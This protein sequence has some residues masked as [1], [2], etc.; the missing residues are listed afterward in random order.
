MRALRS[1]A[2]ACGCTE[3]RTPR[4]ERLLPG[5]SRDIAECLIAFTGSAVAVAR[6]S[7]FSVGVLD[8]ASIHRLLDGTRMSRADGPAVPP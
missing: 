1:S 6:L 2:S 4:L 3:A 5:A 8:V 7:Q